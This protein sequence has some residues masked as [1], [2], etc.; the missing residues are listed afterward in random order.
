MVLSSCPK[1]DLIV[2]QHVRNTQNDD[3]IMTKR[4]C[5]PVSS[6]CFS[7][8]AFKFILLVFIAVLQVLRYQ[9]VKVE[10][11]TGRS[12][13]SFFNKRKTASE[14]IHTLPHWLQEYTTWHQQQRQHLNQSNWNETRF[15]IQRCLE[16]DGACGGTSDRLRS[17]PIKLRLAAEMKR[18]FL[19]HW[20]R[21]TK[22]QEFLVPPFNSDGIDWTVPA[23]LEDKFVF[24]TECSVGP[25]DEAIERAMGDNCS[26]VF[27]LSHF[28]FSGGAEIYDQ[29]LDENDPQDLNFETI[30]R[31]IWRFMFQ[32][33]PP[34]EKII[35]ERMQIMNLAENQ[36]NALHIRSLYSG[37]ES[38]IPDLVESATNCGLSFGKRLPLY[39][40]T[41]SLNATQEALEYASLF[42]DKARAHHTD[43]PPLHLNRGEEY[44]S[45]NNTY[46]KDRP[47]LYYDTFVD[48]YILA[49]AKCIAIGRGT[50]GYWANLISEDPTC[51]VRYF[52]LDK[53]KYAFPDEC[54]PFQ[55][56]SEW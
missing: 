49:R 15:F 25:N 41:D 18:L 1:N 21:P 8:N 55:T 52:S 36:Y 37:Q 3:S 22:L 53:R 26:T 28:G 33:S 31:L 9:L 30:Y 7:P 46:V 19:I 44:L 39:I 43:Q 35:H 2:Y 54:H 38:T 51:V 23:W 11:G 48:L 45:D 16:K 24:R 40:A 20:E 14:I 34:V 32:P 42:T 17:I 4:P 6:S 13:S 50:F 10:Q 12:T 5:S 27:S 29:R 56:D 47:D